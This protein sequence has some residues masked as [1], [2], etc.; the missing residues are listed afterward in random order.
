ITSGE[1]PYSYTFC[2]RTFTVK[3]TLDYHVN[4]H[5]K[6]PKKF[7]CHVYGSTFSAKGSLR[8]HMRLHTG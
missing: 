6:R 8:V 1:K 3:S 7:M 2:K 5:Y 4:T